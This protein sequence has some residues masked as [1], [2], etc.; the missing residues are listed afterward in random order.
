MTTTSPTLAEFLATCRRDFSYL[1]SE[2]GYKEGPPI[3]NEYAIRYFKGNIAVVVE[4]INWGVGVGVLISSGDET[5]PLWAIAKARG[6]YNPPA[7]GQFA[8]L[9][10]DARLLRAVA[11][12]V[13]RGDN[14]V[15]AAAA[16]IVAETAVETAKPRQ[17][18]LP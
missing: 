3:R 7:H 14:A 4:G 11:S 16:R 15:F 9:K 8:Q 18:W 13:L 6:S 10:D 1:T 2:F 12:D 17:S 5:V